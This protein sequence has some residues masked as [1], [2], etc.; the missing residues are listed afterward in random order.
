MDIRKII[1]F[2]EQG[3]LAY[4]VYF[5]KKTNFGYESFSPNVD[6]Q[7]F[8]DIL[9][10]ISKKLNLVLPSE[11]SNKVGS[12]HFSHL[13]KIF[14]SLLVFSSSIFSKKSLTTVFLVI[15]SIF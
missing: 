13:A 5:S 15:S 10:L 14:G 1:S 12:P 3:D 11:N 7:I 6:G 8:Y 2:L 9:D 4:E